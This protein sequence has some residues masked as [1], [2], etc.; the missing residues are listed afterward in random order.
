ML[1]TIDK[2]RCH[3]AASQPHHMGAWADVRF[4]L[5]IAPMRYDT[6]AGDS[7]RITFGM[8]KDSAVVQNQVSLFRHHPP[9]PLR[10]INARFRK[11][12]RGSLSARGA[13]ALAGARFVCDGQQLYNR[14]LYVPAEKG[15]SLLFSP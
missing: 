2:T 13:P 9:T 6:T 11:F 7:H 4:K 15:P 5:C 12:P 8:T 10:A 3:Y 1:M 14:G